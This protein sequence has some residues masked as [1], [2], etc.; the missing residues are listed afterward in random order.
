MPTFVPPTWPKEDLSAAWGAKVAAAITELQQGPWTAFPFS[1]PWTN[2][3]VMDPSWQ[4][5]EYRKVGDM[6]QFRGLAYKNS[7][8]STTMGILP[9]GFRPLGR[10]HFPS[11]CDAGHTYVIPDTDGQVWLSPGPSAGGW[12][13]ITNIRFSVA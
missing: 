2:W 12:V 7:S 6:V 8:S 11:V 9:V 13:S 5:C 3:A 4:V 10:L 1:A